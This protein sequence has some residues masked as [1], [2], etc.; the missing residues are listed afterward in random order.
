M[1]TSPFHE[2]VRKPDDMP[3]IAPIPMEELSSQSRAIVEAG[4]DDGLYATPVPLQI[5]ELG[6]VSASAAK[7]V[8]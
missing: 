5:F 7:S 3:R 8:G 4:V 1:S 6:F 2:P